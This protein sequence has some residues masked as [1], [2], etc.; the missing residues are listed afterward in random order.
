MKDEHLP[1]PNYSSLIFHISSLKNMAYIEDKI[2]ESVDFS[3]VMLDVAEYDNCT[4]KNC[5]FSE[6]NL[7]EVKFS[8]CTFLNCNLSM[9]NL[10]KTAI[11]D[12]VFKD[13]K[14]L[15]LKFEDCNKFGLAMCFE[16]CLLNHSSFYQV[17]MP[18]TVFKSTQL[19]DVDFTESD[20]SQ[21]IFE[22]C[23][24]KNA[25]F[26]T[27]NLEKADFRKAINYAIN[28]DANKIRKA[29]F[30]YLGLAGLLGKY[31]IDIDFSK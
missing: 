21:A 20:F 26:D 30:S 24:L 22:D 7:W 25:I 16:G 18:K 6:V 23:D 12:V 5:N 3:S 15:G 9:A 17:K 2:F 1:P 11:R 31:N 28:P 10:N 29:R 27:T 13:C 8:E 19:Q 4:F 14:M